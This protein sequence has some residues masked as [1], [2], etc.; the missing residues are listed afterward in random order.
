MIMIIYAFLD[1]LDHSLF[2]YHD[3][4]SMMIVVAEEEEASDAI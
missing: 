1:L 4:M 3:P 2:D